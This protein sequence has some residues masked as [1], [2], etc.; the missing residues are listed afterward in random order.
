MVTPGVRSAGRK[1]WREC[2]KNDMDELGSV[3]GCVEKRHIRKTS[4]PS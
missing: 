1:T 2:V 4:D 3:Q